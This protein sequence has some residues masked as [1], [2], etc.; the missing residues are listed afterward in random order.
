MNH[1]AEGRRQA[2]RQG[3]RRGTLPRA[4][5][6]LGAAT[7]LVGLMWAPV[8]AG[9]DAGSGEPVPEM[10]STALLA[11]ALV[12]LGLWRWKGRGKR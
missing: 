4:M 6:R 8:F 10:S 5:R 2:M 9:S 11:S 1:A 7:C 12:G 3:T